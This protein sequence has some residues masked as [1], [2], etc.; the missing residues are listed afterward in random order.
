MSDISES[1]TLLTTSCSSGSSDDEDCAEISIAALVNFDASLDTETAADTSAS[2]VGDKSTVGHSCISNSRAEHFAEQQQI[3]SESLFENPSIAIGSNSNINRNDADV[4][5]SEQSE[6]SE[7]SEQSE[8]SDNGEHSERSENSEQSERSENSERSKNSIDNDHSEHSE[9][10]SDSEHGE[11]NTHSENHKHSEHGEHAVPQVPRQHKAGV[12]NDLKTPPDELSIFAMTWN[13]ESVLIAEALQRTGQEPISMY[14]D[15]WLGCLQPDFLPQL[16]R[17]HIFGSPQEA[18]SSHN[19]N[20]NAGRHHLLVIAL[21]ESAKP[22]DYLLSNALSNELGERYV[23]V[24]RG[25]M[26]GIG[27]TSMKALKREGALRARGLRL[28]IYARKDFNRF[29][30]FQADKAILCTMQ[31]RFTRGKGGYGIVLRVD[32]FGLLAFLNI[33]LPFVA[34]TLTRGNHSRLATGVRNQNEAFCTILKHFLSKRALHHL[35]VLGDLNYRVMHLENIV[36]AAGLC[37]EM[38][39]NAKFRDRI[40]RQCDELKQSI[41][42]RHLPLPFEEGVNNAGPQFM[43]TAKMKHDRPPNSTVPG[44]YVFGEHNH[45]NPSW[46]DRILYLPGSLQKTRTISQLLCDAEHQRHS[47]DEDGD[48]NGHR[49]HQQPANSNEPARCTYYDRFE[50]GTTM[51]KSD[52][53]AVCAYYTIKRHV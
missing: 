39:R 36:D 17:K 8:R 9:R 28:A 13:T 52:H 6:R 46:C 40:Y 33:H 49:H 50:S 2:S 10:C 44:A 20:N 5:N 26:I 18:G 30:H 29:V 35:F 42:T 4:G 43:P 12:D 23:L 7:N 21:Q 51:T 22:G 24:K 48:D 45:R 31:D 16:V 14:S 3:E 53:C 15:S 19:S 25:R 38:V 34:S 41:V 11:K 27:L 37:D 47:A 32:G 1:A